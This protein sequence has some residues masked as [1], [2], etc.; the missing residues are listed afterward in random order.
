MAP[1]HLYSGSYL[2]VQRGVFHSSKKVYEIFESKRIFRDFLLSFLENKRIF[3]QRCARF[4]LSDTPLVLQYQ[5]FWL[6]KSSL[7][8]PNTQPPHLCAGYLLDVL[9][10]HCCKAQSVLQTYINITNSFDAIHG[11][12]PMGLQ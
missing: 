10:C 6:A 9:H 11:R 5:G 3:C 12:E 8:V 1:R 4:L 7:D 2:I